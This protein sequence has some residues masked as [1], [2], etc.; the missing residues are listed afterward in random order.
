MNHGVC[1]IALS[2]LALIACAAGDGPFRNPGMPSGGV[3]VHRI[4][5]LP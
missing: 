3:S 1:T 4:D 5:S 2:A